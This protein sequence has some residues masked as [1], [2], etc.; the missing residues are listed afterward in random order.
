MPEYRIRWEID[1]I[2]ADSPV[3]A[4]RIA[5]QIQRDPESIAS[6]FLIQ[7]MYADENGDDWTEIDLSKE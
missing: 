6:V 3:V 2:E 5:Q 1:G 4:A 7:P